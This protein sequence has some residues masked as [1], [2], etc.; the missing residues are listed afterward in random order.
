MCIAVLLHSQTSRDAAVPTFARIL[1]PLG[2]LF[3]Q[4]VDCKPDTAD[5]ALRAILNFKTD[6]ILELSMRAFR[7]L[8][9]SSA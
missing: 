1:N 2:S 3:S 9:P 5:T 8:V 7:I 6:A 4:L